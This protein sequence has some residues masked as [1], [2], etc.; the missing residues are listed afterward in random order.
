MSGPDS[1]LAYAE[2][3]VTTVDH[4]RKL[5]DFVKQAANSRVIG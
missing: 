3:G 5:L 1:T 4:A 2:Y